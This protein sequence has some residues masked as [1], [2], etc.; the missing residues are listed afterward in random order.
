MTIRCTE[1]I[2]TETGKSILVLDLFWLAGSLKPLDQRG[3]TNFDPC[4]HFGRARDVENTISCVFSAW[5]DMAREF[6][7]LLSIFNPHCPQTLSISFSYLY[8]KL[9]VSDPYHTV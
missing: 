8:S 3:L 6:L 4:W 7:L 2:H 1:Q 5:V 9:R